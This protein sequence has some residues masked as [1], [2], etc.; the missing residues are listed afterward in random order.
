MAERT[1]RIQAPDGTIL[2]IAGPE[3]ATPEQLRAA[4]DRAFAAQP[5]AQAEQPKASMASR[6]VQGL[7]SGSVGRPQTGASTQQ[8]QQD[9]GQRRMLLSV[10]PMASPTTPS[11]L[12]QA[13]A[14]TVRYGPPAAAALIAT[15]ATLPTLGG[16]AIVSGIAGGT[17]FASSLLG[18]FIG[19]G[20]VD[21]REAG[22]DAAFAAMPYLR[23]T[24]RAIRVPA[25][26]AGAIG[27]VEA[28]E[29]I[30]GDY[31]PPKT[32]REAGER[33]A[34]ASTLVGVGSLFNE[35]AQAIQ[36]G[37]ARRVATA[38]ERPS[39]T[40]MMSEAFPVTTKL[41][42]RVIQNGNKRARER[43]ERLSEGFDEAVTNSFPELPS[44]TALQRDLQ[45]K[46]SW[47]DGIRRQVQAAD[48]DLV[49][50]QQRLQQE[51]SGDNVRAINALRKEAADKALA[52]QSNRLALEAAERIALGGRATNISE[53]GLANQVSSLNRTVQASK[54]ALREGIGAAYG[55]AGIGPNTGVVPWDSVSRAIAGKSR[56]GGAF[57]GR[58]ARKETRDALKNYFDKNST[59]GMLSLEGYR[60]LQEGIAGQLAAEG[61]SPSQA[62]RIAAEA[63]DAVKGAADRY[64]KRTMPDQFGKWTQARTL[65]ARDFALRD[66]DAM[67]KLNNGDVR[68]FY[69]A[70]TKEGRGQTLEAL[71]TYAK[72]MEDAG[73]RSAAAAFRSEVNSVISKGVLYRASEGQI[74]IGADTVNELI[75]PQKL[76]TELDR[77]RAL[78]FPV[79]DLGLGTAKQIK[80]ASRISSVG[81]ENGITTEQ[82][83]KFLELAPVIGE[84]QAVAR[85]RYFNSVRDEML[86]NGTRKARVAQFQA[87]RAEQSARA[88]AQVKAD[89]VARAEQD[90]LVQLVTNPEFKV[91]SGVLA[92]SKFNSNLMSLEPTAASAFVEAM[93]NAGKT[94]DLENLRRG[95]SYS[96]M[97]RFR[98]TTDGRSVLDENAINKFFF[99]K[100]GADKVRRDTFKRLVG[101]SHYSSMETNFAKPLSRVADTRRSLGVEQGE[102]SL[103]F[104][105]LRQRTPATGG[106]QGAFVGGVRQI[107]DFIDNRR[108]NLLYTLYMD[109]RTAPQWAKVVQGTSDLANQPVLA[110]AVRL[111]NEK[112]Q[113]ERR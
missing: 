90:P 35:G 107:T 2:T 100:D 71:N 106:F 111:A 92:S 88:N 3:N 31:E 22:S 50:T 38:A 103:G 98:Q 56:A 9:E 113:E 109:P 30:R 85:M 4:A 97:N 91:P 37:N 5:P 104:L 93:Q 54:A 18:Q 75:N 40:V 11:E 96:V 89:A 39:S 42:A 33:W 29:A 51:L 19:D 81:R 48:E 67:V 66:T 17:G 95:L 21:M 7:A 108:Y 52:T 79:D 43:M 78:K 72:L 112:D 70:I 73:Q 24:Q 8:P 105:Y 20:E 10:N 36:A 69:D 23:G 49:R 102:G 26:I 59:N 60:N 63:Y 15:P 65:A 16:A 14:N 44:N 64:M 94:G 58:L 46:K 74:G 28:A 13:A 99:G 27:T 34:L 110:T 57:E 45:E 101:D 68:G 1:Y 80:A 53:L 82:L 12:R 87:R 84:A 47:I 83:G 25:N 32:F 62:Q 55:E 6:M 86:S 77:L 41:E 76:W 61:A